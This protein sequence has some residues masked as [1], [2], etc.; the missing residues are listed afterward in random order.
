MV[1]LKVAASLKTLRAEHRFVE[2]Q[3]LLRRALMKR[4]LQTA[5]VEVG[6]LEQVKEVCTA[7]NIEFET[8]R[9]QQQAA[10]TAV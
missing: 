1:A 9:H 10:A 7:Y 2:G 8:W 5:L 3:A 6:S 4:K